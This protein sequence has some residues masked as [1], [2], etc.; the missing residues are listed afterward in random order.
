VTVETPLGPIRIKVAS[1][2]GRVL[3]AA[4][5]FDDCAKLAAARNL[6][7]KDVQAMAI[8]AYG[9]LRLLPDQTGAS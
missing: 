9:N 6:A 8:Q 2:D 4:P 7:V 5:E 1:R 3:N